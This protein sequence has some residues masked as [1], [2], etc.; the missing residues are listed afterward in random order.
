MVLASRS[1]RVAR[2]GQGLESQLSSVLYAAKL[3]S[4]DTADGDE[5]RA[6][7]ESSIDFAQGV[8]R[9]VLI[10]TAGIPDKGLIN[11]LHRYPIRDERVTQGRRR[12]PCA[13][14]REHALP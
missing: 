7:L 13:S 8:V 3:L 12:D 6:L 11:E 5:V 9:G 10:H 2:G 4:C 1:G 14:A